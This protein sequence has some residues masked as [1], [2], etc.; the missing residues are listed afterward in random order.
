MAETTPAFIADEAISVQEAARKLAAPARSAFEKDG[1]L[2]KVE[3]ELGSLWSDVLTAAEQT[4]HGQQER[5]VEIL[6]A[7]KELPQ[8]VHESKKLE[9]WDQEQHWNELPLF[10]ANCRD[11]L[12]I[13]QGK[14]GDAFTNLNAFYARI[15]ATNVHDLGLY[16]IWII[17]EALEDPEEGKI[18]KETSP[19][20]LHAASVWFVYAAES[21]ATL[22]E[23]QKQF[24]GKIARPGKSL[25]AR[26]DEA[27]WKGFSSDRWQIW[28]DRLASL[29]DA[30]LTPEVKSSISQAL[31]KAF[32]N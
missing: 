9:I 5:L 8:P 32:G 31:D 18:A 14:S 17:R 2:A 7:I 16:A 11:H 15:T 23:D 6:R 22:S 1:D 25:L 19:D 20:L 12:G 21:L 10:G 4:P 28:L 27:G 29:K 24:D 26:Q 30:D 13:A 3:S